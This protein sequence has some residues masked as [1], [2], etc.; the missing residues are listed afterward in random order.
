MIGRLNG[1]NHLGETAIHLDVLIEHVIPR[2][3]IQLDEAA[4]RV[5]SLG[6]DITLHCS[7]RLEATGDGRHDARSITPGQ[8]AHEFAHAVAEPASQSRPRPTAPICRIADEHWDCGPSRSAKGSQS[9]SKSRA[10][11][12]GGGA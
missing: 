11:R 3:L 1:S 5:A 10:Q 9:G 8:S 12:S 2:R 6:D 4:L 7:P